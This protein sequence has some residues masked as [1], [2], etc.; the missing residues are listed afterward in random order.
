MSKQHE[1]IYDYRDDHN[2]EN[3]KKLAR[4]AI[5]LLVISIL[6]FLFSHF[7]LIKQGEKFKQEI[8]ALKEN[9]Q[10]LEKEVEVL[11][12][13]INTVKTVTKKLKR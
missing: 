12:G 8:P 6:L 1:F 13:N 11:N 10:K 9:K 3:N 2:E 4:N 5:I 7:V